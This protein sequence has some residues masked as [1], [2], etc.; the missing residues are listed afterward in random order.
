MGVLDLSAVPRLGRAIGQK[1]LGVVILEDDQGVERDLHLLSSRHVQIHVS[2]C[3]S[4]EGTGDGAALEHIATAAASL[5]PSGSV[6]AIGYGCTSGSFKFGA[7]QICSAIVRH[8]PSIPACTVSDSLRAA[9]TAL[10]VQRLSI[11]TPYDISLTKRT[12]DQIEKDGA[13]VSGIGFMNSPSDA[14]I[15]A[16]EPTEIV[17]AGLRILSAHEVD[18]LFIACNALRAVSAVRR[19]EAVSGK[20]VLTSSQVLVWNLLRLGAIPNGPSAAEFGRLFDVG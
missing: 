8:R 1:H 9:M 12:A 18:A 20:W 15:A 6:A 10:R 7:S 3:R 4:Y 14:E 13:T 11:L 19:L 16:I 17:E 5:L 2:R